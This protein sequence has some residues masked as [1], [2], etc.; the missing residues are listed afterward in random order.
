MGSVPVRLLKESMAKVAGVSGAF[1]EFGVYR[2]ASFVYIVEDGFKNMRVV[3]GFDSFVGMDEPTEKDAGY[4]PKGR[5]DAGGPEKCIEALARVGSP[6]D[7]YK[8][9]QGFIPESLSK[10]DFDTIAFAHVDLDQYLPTKLVLEWVW[11]RLSDGGV[12]LCHDYFKGR[13]RL[14]ALA[15]DEFLEKV[16]GSVD[17]KEEDYTLQITRRR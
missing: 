14:A 11:N 10:A 7:A 6:R 13:R 16:G 12:I 1:V 2:G 5:L 8:L 3:R 9:I 15:I 17:S 4:Y